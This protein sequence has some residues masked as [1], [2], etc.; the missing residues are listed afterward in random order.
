MRYLAILLIAL[1]CSAQTL[2]TGNAKTSGACSPAVSGNNNQF[3]I[4]CQGVPEKLQKQFVDLL[5]A[6]ARDEAKSAEIAS[7]LDGCI[8]GVTQLVQRETPRHLSLEQQQI[9][10]NAIAPFRGQRIGTVVNNSKRDNQGYLADLK[11]ALVAA[12]WDVYEQGLMI[13]GEES[14]GIVISVREEDAQMPAVQAFLRALDTAGVQ[15]VKFEAYPTADPDSKYMFGKVKS[16]EIR[17]QVGD[18][19]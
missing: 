13:S 18:K 11:Q 15:D 5:N 12:H 10:V 1:N 9:I 19:E 7:K 17:L 16:G 2:A 4:T 8:A 3:T 6:M 14:V